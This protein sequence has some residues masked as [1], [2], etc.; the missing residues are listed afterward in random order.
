MSCFQPAPAILWR[1]A[2]LSAYS[3]MDDCFRRLG[4]ASR[5]RGRQSDRADSYQRLG[6]GDRARSVV[7]KRRLV[8]VCFSHPG[9]LRGLETSSTDA[10]AYGAA[11]IGAPVD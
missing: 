2:K 3:T 7:G 11:R 8:S 10:T 9:G 5:V 4:I 1:G 6:P